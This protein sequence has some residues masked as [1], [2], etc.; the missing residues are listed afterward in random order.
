[1]TIPARYILDSVALLH[2]DPENDVLENL[3]QGMADVKG[4]IG[5]G[6]AIVKEEWLICRTVGGLPLVEGGR[7]SLEVLVA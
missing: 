3:V 5:V 2:L 6:R 1:M 7:T 4:A